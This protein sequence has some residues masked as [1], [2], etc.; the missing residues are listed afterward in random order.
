[1]F[2]LNCSSQKEFW[3][4]LG[5]LGVLF[6]EVLGW[7]CCLESALGLHWAGGGGVP[8]GMQTEAKREKAGYSMGM[9]RHEKSTGN[10]ARKP[11]GERVNR[12]VAT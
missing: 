3:E 8:H 1:M 11:D 10:R 2:P 4:V 6:W 7:G 9:E 12:S 5:V